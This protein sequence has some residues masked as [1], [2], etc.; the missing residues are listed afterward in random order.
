MKKLSR[1]LFTFSI[2]F[3]LT[4]CTPEQAAPAPD[5]DPPPTPTAEEEVPPTPE[6]ELEPEPTATPV[7]EAE[8]PPPTE[9]NLALYTDDE[10]RAAYQEVAVA[11]VAAFQEAYTAVSNEDPAALQDPYTVA[12]LFVNAIYRSE[13]EPPAHDES[14]YLPTAADEAIIIVVLGEYKDD[15]VW[16]HKIRLE[17]SMQA[18]TWQLDWVGEQWRCRRGDAELMENWHTTLCP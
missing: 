9:A 12:N 14:F 10:E 7:A 2:F 8:G 17:L 6:P 11:E 4:A 1:L 15:S 5:L 3:L 18:D 16:G 13:E